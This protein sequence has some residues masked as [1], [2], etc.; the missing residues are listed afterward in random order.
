MFKK[1]VAAMLAGLM[2]IAAVGCGQNG[3]G[4]AGSSESAKDTT[5]ASSE[6]AT[7][8]AT[9]TE[10]AKAEESVDWKAPFDETVQLHVIRE[11]S[12]DD[13]PDGDDVTSNIWTRLYED[14]LN[15]EL[16]TDWVSDDYY[17]KLNLSIA[18]GELPDVFV[19]KDVQLQQLLDA[20]M[21]MDI[22][23]FYE[24]YASDTLRKFMDTE[25]KILDTAKRNDR[26]YAIP[27][28]YTGYQ[29]AFMWIRNDWLEQLGGEAP[30]TIDDL[31]KML[32]QIK[33][34]SG[35][36]ALAVG[37]DLDGLYRMAEAWNAYP[38]IWVD[39]GN[40]Q[41]IYG[42]VAP[43]MKDALTAWN[44]WYEEGIIKSDFAT[45]NLDAIKEDIVNGKCGAQVWQSSWGWVFGRDELKNQPLEAYFFCHEMPTVSGEKAI[46]PKAFNNN[47]YIVVN[48]NCKNPEAVIKCIDYYV[49]MM[50][51]AY[52]VGDMTLEEVQPFNSLQH[53]NGPFQVANSTYDFTR[54]YHVRQA[55]DSGDTSYLKSSQ[56]Q[57]D[58]ERTMKWINDKDADAVGGA[59]QMGL[60]GCGTEL[61][62][63]LSEEG[64]V[65]DSKMWGPQ[66][67]TLLDYGATLDDIL[68]EGFTKIIMGAEDIDYFDTL[69][70]QWYNAGGQAATDAVNEAY[71]K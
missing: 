22:T 14:K 6:A 39:D 44:K 24:T 45:M 10:E 18:S 27:R 15:V 9:K 43:E 2:V 7:S 51:D 53:V 19:V 32:L 16:V 12:G 52:A 29:P 42:A 69:V 11:T 47:G 59:V 23:D 8:E 71:N 37:Q 25:S 55:V 34:I 48:K 46:Y 21:I 17:T 5:P 57:G 54:C 68:L 65:L 58:Y 13:Y 61:A 64:R 56:E 62:R 40:G 66:P 31:E 30:T 50:N 3:S 33:D 60:P 1:T 38:T 67:Q 4:N 20:D 41:I 49:Y 63:I 26:I 35:D 36:Y 70:E 28:L